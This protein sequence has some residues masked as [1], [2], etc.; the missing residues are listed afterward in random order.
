MIT[1][2]E[3]IEQYQ[4]IQNPI[5]ETASFCG[6]LFET[7]GLELDYV[8]A[9]RP[10]TIWTLVDGVDEGLRIINGFH[11]VNRIGYFV[12]KYSCNTETDVILEA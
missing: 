2:N 1:E 4:P 9:Q 10:E 3:W 6:S 12:T 7:F 11:I 5:N 8:K